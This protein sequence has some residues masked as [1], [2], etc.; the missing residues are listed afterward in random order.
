MIEGPAIGAGVSL[1][2]G[3]AGF[4]GSRLTEQLRARGEAVRAFDLDRARWDRLSKLGASMV[5]GDITSRASVDSAMNGVTRVFHVAA[6]YELGTRDAARM[7]AINVDGTRNVV[8]AAVSRDIP[9]VHVS[10]VAAL[11]PT[12][13][14]LEDESHRSSTNGAT[15]SAYE[16]TKR[17]AHEC[18]R[19]IVEGSGGRARVRIALPATIYGAGDPSLV[20]KAHAWLARSH[21]RAFV[22]PTMRLAFVHVDDCADGLVRVAERGRDG[23]EYILCADSVTLREWFEAFARATHRPPPRV[24]VPDWLVKATGV[25]VSR[26]PGHAAPLRLLREATAMSDGFHWAFSGAKARRELGWSPRSFEAGLDEVARTARPRL[27]RSV[28]HT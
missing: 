4:L 24:S 22:A 27:R 16:S 3:A 15:R 28:V 21:L 23:E 5:H 11:G 26:I 14:A 18:V 25:A 19:R 9:V 17:E 2:T 7:R 20:G 12:G 6:L 10:S 8:E 13:V 1:V